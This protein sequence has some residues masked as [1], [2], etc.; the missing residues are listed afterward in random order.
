[1]EKIDAASLLLGIILALNVTGA[2]DT[3]FYALE[4]RTTDAWNALFASMLILEILVIYLLVA[5]P[6]LKKTRKK[7]DKASEFRQGV[8]KTLSLELKKRNKKS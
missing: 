7:H 2:Y 6:R 3:A 1:M 5:Y 4:E 8:N